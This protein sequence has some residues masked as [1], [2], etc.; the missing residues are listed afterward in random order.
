MNEKKTKL[1]WNVYV[2]NINRQKIE[3]YNIFEH[4][5]FMEDLIKAKKE[6]QKNIKLE[7]LEKSPKEIFEEQVRRALLYHYWSKCEWEIIL[8]SWP[9]SSNFNDEKIDV[10]SQVMNNK[11]IFMDYVFE[12][13]KDIKK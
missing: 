10:Y 12:H 2:E 3:V 9:P 4:G 5:G 11:Q 8:T 13:M 7:G 1:C 6:Y